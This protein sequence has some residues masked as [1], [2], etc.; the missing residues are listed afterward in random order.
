M[1]ATEMFRL[2]DSGWPSRNIIAFIQECVILLR[3]NVK[4]KIGPLYQ[5]QSISY[6]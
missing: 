5:L 2:A 6:R 4:H 3:K 1:S